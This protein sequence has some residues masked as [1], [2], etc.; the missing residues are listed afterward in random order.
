MKMVF[1]S[2]LEAVEVTGLEFMEHI[3]EWS[4][5]RMMGNGMT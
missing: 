3:K 4:Q 5:G 1:L 2:V